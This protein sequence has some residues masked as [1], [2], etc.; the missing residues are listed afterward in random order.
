[1]RLRLQGLPARAQE[2]LGAAAVIGAVVDIDLLREVLPDLT[3]GEV[4]DAIDA[5]LPR[6]VFRETGN[7]GRVQFVHDLLRE[8]SYGDLSA[9]RRRSLHRRVGEQLERRREQG[10]AI[11][12]AVLADHFKNAE[13]RPRSFTYSLE[14][15]EAALNAYAFN[16]A[17]THLNGAL[18]LLPEDAQDATKYRLWD[19]LGKAQR[20]SGRI[21]ESIAAFGQSL[22]YAGDWLSRANVEEGIGEAYHRKGRFDDAIHHFDVALR[23][24][25]YPRSR[26]IAGMILDMGKT[27]VYFHML[28]SRLRTSP[29]AGA[30]APG[31]SRSP[32]PITNG[33][34]ASLRA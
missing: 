33:W 3:E 2:V 20:S 10:Q 34:P 21:D 4:L 31:G 8:L 15:A 5:L 22:S 1:M 11:A 27:A 26:S 32:T 13:D 29:I 28:P 14:A 24:V 23:E 12:A 7:A 17:I 6:R 30:T 25:G 19:M 9:T 16:N 18:D